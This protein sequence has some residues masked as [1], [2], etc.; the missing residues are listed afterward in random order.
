VRHH[1]AGGDPE[2]LGE[3]FMAGTANASS[4]AMIFTAGPLGK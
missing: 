3:V 2:V 1:A 4:M